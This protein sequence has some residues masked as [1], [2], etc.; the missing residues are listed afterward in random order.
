MAYVN[1]SG[2]TGRADGRNLSEGHANEN[3]KALQCLMVKRAALNDPVLQADW[4]KKNL[5]WVPHER[6]GFV[7]GSVIENKGDLAVVELVES[8]Q[9]IQVSMDD[10]QKMNPPKFDKVED[11]ADLSCLNE[12]S[13][14]HNLKSRYYSDLIYVCAY[15]LSSDHENTLLD[16]F[17]SFLRCGESVQETANLFRGVD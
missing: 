4:T 7:A 11:M 12:A 17:G 16:L 9:R 5:L 3:T 14:L 15:S 6:E 2:A 10:C 1:G 8:G 13:V